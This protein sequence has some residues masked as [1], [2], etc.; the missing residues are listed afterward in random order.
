M[1]GFKP[2]QTDGLVLGSKVQS[3]SWPCKFE[4]VPTHGAIAASGQGDGVM[5]QLHA[6][7]TAAG[8]GSPLVLRAVSFAQGEPR[9]RQPRFRHLDDVICPLRIHEARIQV[10]PA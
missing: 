9:R 6:D 1:T 4:P 8:W 5:Q 7:D 2:H 3:E 10:R